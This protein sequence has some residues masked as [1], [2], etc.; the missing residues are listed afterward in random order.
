M[1]NWESNCYSKLTETNWTLWFVNRNVNTC[2]TENL[3]MKRKTISEKLGKA[4]WSKKTY[5]S[6]AISKRMKQ[7]NSPYQM[8]SMTSLL[9]SDQN[10]QQTYNIEEKNILIISN[11]QKHVC[12]W[13]QLLL[14][15]LL[16]LPVSLI[17]IKSWP[18]WYRRYDCKTVAIELS[19]LLAIIL[20]WC[21][22]G[23]V[24][25]N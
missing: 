18:R 13:N 14:K 16:R 12:I 7:K 1:S 4:Y 25:S 3:R 17:Q 19:E 21:N 23:V 10:L 2:C 20:Y 24:R 11:K 9:I 5:N 15:K 22:D 6:T 8:R